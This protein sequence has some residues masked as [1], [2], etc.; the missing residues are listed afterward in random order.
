MSCRR[1]FSVQ[2]PIDPLR[3]SLPRSIDLN[4]KNLPYISSRGYDADVYRGTNDDDFDSVAKSSTVV[5]R[6]CKGSVSSLVRITSDA[7]RDGRAS[8]NEIPPGSFKANKPKTSSVVDGPFSDAF[9]DRTNVQTSPRWNSLYTWLD[10]IEDRSEDFHGWESMTADVLIESDIPS[11]NN[12]Q[13]RGVSIYLRSQSPTPSEIEARSEEEEAALQENSESIWQP[14]LAMSNP[15]SPAPVI[16]LTDE[17]KAQM[18]EHA[19]KSPLRF[20]QPSLPSSP[21]FQSKIPNRASGDRFIHMR[22]P[23]VSQKDSFRMSKPP[24]T[25]T[26]TE[27]KLRR[28]TGF[29]DPFGPSSSSGSNFITHGQQ[30]LLLQSAPLRAADRLALTTDFEEATQNAQSYPSGIVGRIPSTN[31]TRS[32]STHVPDGRG[33]LLS[34]GT[35]PRFYPSKLLEKDIAPRSGSDLYEKRLA[36][37][38]DIDLAE[39]VLV[40][41]MISTERDSF[42]Q[43]LDQSRQSSS[44]FNQNLSRSFWQDNQWRREGVIACKIVY[45]YLTHACKVD[46]I[47]SEETSQNAEKIDFGNTIQMSFLHR[48]QFQADQS[49]SP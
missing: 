3:Q 7:N 23:G 43:H 21:K 29:S 27:R 25:L 19:T 28:R 15:A 10:G 17:D 38:L 39:R 35:S 49:H 14:M 6:A 42:L 48:C 2:L 16:P 41:D 20:H 40:P 46:I 24:S 47:Y 32:I 4:R 26:P 5:T 30:R 37:A 34:S 13:Q 33:H 45:T 11:G 1:C 36:L 18:Q 22:R 8:E 44:K 9:W 31:P 12:R